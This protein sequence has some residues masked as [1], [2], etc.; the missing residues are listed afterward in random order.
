MLRCMV[1]GFALSERW[2]GWSDLGVILKAARAAVAAGPLDPLLCEVTVEWD[3]D[4]TILASL[5]ALDALLASGEE[6]MSVDIWLAHV[7]EEDAN[8]TLNYN[9][10]WLQLNG[11]GL[12]WERSRQAYY[13]AQVELALAYGI[14][15]FKLPKLPKDTVQETRKRL[16]GSQEGDPS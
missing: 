8:L 14:T 1:E 5:D 15:T 9:G 6:P 7:D 11:A 13:A 12:D 4:T 3:D 16:R 10:R 2:N